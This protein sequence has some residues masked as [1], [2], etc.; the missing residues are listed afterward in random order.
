MAQISLETRFGVLCIT[1]E[2]GAIC[3]VTWGHARYPDET[4]VLRRAGEQLRAY[5]AGETE[6]FDLPL[7]V[8][9]SS[10]VRAVCD[11]M[12]EI[13]FGETRTYGEIA[14][15]VGA[16][17]QA[18]G[19][20]CGQN[21]IPVIIPCH[22]VMGSGGKLTGYSGGRGVETKIALLRHER[23]AGLLI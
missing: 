7:V 1:E 13:P 10:L 17:A 4:D 21:P 9:A 11:E 2:D 16:S 19:Q 12:S 18:V 15:K 6:S 23:A 14:T 5:D 22:R 3:R 20:A 8:R